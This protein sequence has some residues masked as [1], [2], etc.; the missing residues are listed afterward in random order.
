[1]AAGAAGIDAAERVTGTDAQIG[2][3]TSDGSRAQTTIAIATTP[4]TSD[5]VSNGL[6]PRHADRFDRSAG[7]IK[8]GGVSMAFG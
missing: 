5:A 1:M 3:T 6:R 4:K 8:S 7:L 2:T